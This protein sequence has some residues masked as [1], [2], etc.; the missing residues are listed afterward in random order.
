[1]NKQEPN[2]WQ[3]HMRQIRYDR[4][5][6]LS[7]EVL[8][9]RRLKLGD[10]HPH[11]LESWN[12]LIELYEALNKPEKAEEWRAKLTQTDIAERTSRVVSR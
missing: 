1:M 11:T 8:K 7:A 6:R 10:I 9:G 2:C 3:L 4:V 12:N 5:D